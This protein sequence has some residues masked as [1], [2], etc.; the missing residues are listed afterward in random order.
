[1]PDK[2]YVFTGPGNF[3]VLRRGDKE[4]VYRQGDS[5]PLSEAEVEHNRLYGSAQFEGFEP[6][7]T[8]APAVARPEDAVPFDDTGRPYLANEKGE[9]LKPGSAAWEKAMQARGAG[10][11]AVAAES[12][13][14]KQQADTAAAAPRVSQP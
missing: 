4:E 12:A 6:V 2:G 11:A 14:I 1:M 7:F 5:V 9:L 8:A 3:F 10:K 13:A